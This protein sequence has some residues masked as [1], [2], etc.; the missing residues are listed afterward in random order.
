MHRVKAAQR[1]IQAKDPSPR[2]VPQK[3]KEIGGGYRSHLIGQTFKALFEWVFST[4]FMGSLAFV[5]GL[6]GRQFHLFDQFVT[7]S[8]GLPNY[9][10]YLYCPTI[11]FLSTC[12]FIFTRSVGAETMQSLPQV[13]TMVCC[14]G[15]LAGAIIE[16]Q[17]EV[18]NAQGLV[19]VENFVY[20]SL[21]CVALSFSIYV[22]DYKW[23]VSWKSLLVRL[24]AVIVPVWIS[25][26]YHLVPLSSLF[27]Q[28]THFVLFSFGVAFLEYYVTH[29]RTR[30][31]MFSSVFPS[32]YIGCLVQGFGM[33]AL[34]TYYTS[35]RI[36]LFSPSWF[37]FAWMVLAG[38][39]VTVFAVVLHLV[40]WSSEQIFG[41]GPHNT[42]HVSRCMLFACCFVYLCH[43][44]NH[45]G[46]FESQPWIDAARTI[47]KK[48]GW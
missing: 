39:P 16:E 19:N 40:S 33:I 43:Q 10:S 29:A 37:S 8:P 30:W 7:L 42:V 47:K 14:C 1:R 25:I 23:E 3:Q 24:V 46:L 28:S 21:A 26:L 18:M 17:L 45:F 27:L 32:P 15:V 31:S 44:F 41:P 11:V 38:A 20:L 9:P 5:F 12:L 36:R 34:T 6:I 22:F 4:R 35:W 13:L 48:L 2:V